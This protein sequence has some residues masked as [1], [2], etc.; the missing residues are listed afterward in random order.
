MAKRVHSREFKL[1]AVRLVRDQK[2]PVLRV[3]R[4]LGVHPN[5]LRDWIRKLEQDPEHAFPGHGQMKPADAEVAR[6]QRELKRVTA[7]R[8]I[9][10]KAIGYFAKEPA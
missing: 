10:K 1:E 6:L 5:S 4:E 7:E 9:L 3:A 8:D 2:L